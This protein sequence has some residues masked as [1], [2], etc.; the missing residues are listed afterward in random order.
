MACFHPLRAWRL[1]GGG[2]TLREPFGDVGQSFLRLPCGGC[3]GCR[4]ARAR[5]WAFRCMLELGEHSSSRWCTLTYD[6]DHLP[7]T[8]RKRDLSGFVKRVRA[9]GE[10]VRFFGCGEYGERTHR[11]HYHAILFGLSNEPVVQAAWPYGFARVDPVSPAA[12]SYVAGYCAKKIGWK[13]ESGERV[14]CETG[15]VFDWQ[16]PFT[17]MSRRPGIGAA[18]RKFSASWRRFAV[19]AGSPIPVPRYLHA[20]WADSASDLDVFLLESEKRREAVLRDSSRARLDAGEAIAVCA[21]GLNAAKRQK[22]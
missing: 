16:A 15:E 19:H 6:D 9:R 11:P 8:L 4:K 13:L 12:V 20:S 18:A 22:F 1:P 17:L 10:R 14:D 5:E 3:L 2:T 7:P 21:A